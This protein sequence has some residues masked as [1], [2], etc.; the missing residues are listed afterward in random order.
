MMLAGR[1]DII[2]PLSKGDT[3]ELTGNGAG[4]KNAIIPFDEKAEGF[5]CGEGVGF[6]LL[7]RFED[8][9]HDQDHI[10]GVIIGAGISGTGASNC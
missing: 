8:A 5:I 1:A 10:Y 4:A 7:K 9:V 3:Y 6:V 2:M